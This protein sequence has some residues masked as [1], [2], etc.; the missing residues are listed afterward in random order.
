M[1]T[2]WLSDSVGRID[3]IALAPNARNAMFPLLEAVMNS[4]QAIEERFGPDNLAKGKIEIVIHTQEGG[5]Y[6]GFT[7]TDNGVG[8]N[9]DNLISV[10]K[11]DSRKKAK[12]GGKGVGRLLWLKVSEGAQIRSNFFREGEGVIASEF[13]FTAQEPLMGYV[14]QSAETDRIE[15]SITIDPFRSEFASRLPRKLE[16]IANRIIAHFVSYFTNISH[17]QIVVRDERDEIDLFDAFSEKVERDQDFPFK[18]DGEHDTFIFHCFLLPKSISDDE[19]SV[20]ALYLGANGRSVTRHELDSVLGMKAIGGSFAFLGY[21]ESEYL[22]RHAN[23]T[24]TSFT[25]DE[26]QQSAIVDRSKELAKTFLGPEIADIRDRQARRI[27]AIGKEHPRFFHEA[28][29]AQ[30]VAGELHLSKQSEEE[31][32]IELSRKSLRTYKKRKREY[33]TSYGKGLPD[34]EEQKDALL[35]KLQADAIASLAEYVARRKAIL[36]IFEAG[37]RFDSIEDER[38]HYERVVHGIVCPLRSSQDELTYEDHNLWLLDDRLAFYTYFNSDRPFSK[39]V[40]DSKDAKRPDVSIFEIGL[41]FNIED[42]NQPVS[43]IEFKQPK[44]DN[45]TLSDNPIVQVRDYVERFRA[46]NE[47]TKFDGTV[48]RP[49][50][51]ETPFH[52]FIVADVTKSLLNVMKQYGQFGRRAGGQSYYWWDPN[53]KIFIEITPYAEVLSSAKARNQAFFEKLGLA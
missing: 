3:N 6:S 14:E 32:F 15:T 27:E 51:D 23:D 24:R 53:F 11:F 12:I 52:C 37:I 10:R 45:Y 19:K 42:M 9:R 50:N 30:A 20:N 48:L 1:E 35:D 21:V 4:I 8:F 39:Q 26:D 25:F 22:N 13:R 47:V 33:A 2:G 5:G 36:E 49:V 40:P 38:A 28:K 43:I 46:A 18:I 16:T 17:P 31:I 41:G 44:R 34:L 7:I 29:D